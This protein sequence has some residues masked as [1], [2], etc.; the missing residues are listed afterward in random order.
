M[1]LKAIERLE[2]ELG[3]TLPPEYVRL[4]V[5]PR[6]AAIG[7]VSVSDDVELIIERTKEHREGFAGAPEWPQQFVYV[8]DEDDACPYALDCT[9]GVIVWTDH[10]NLDQRPLER[11]GS[12]R[13]RMRKPDTTARRKQRSGGN[14]GDR[15][16]GWS[17]GDRFARVL[18][19]LHI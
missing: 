5:Q 13:P 11:Y 2:K 10:G 4:L 15:R 1:D 17:N 18:A 9:T 6:P 14:S 19:N 16:A 7:T 12:W 8:G 3:V